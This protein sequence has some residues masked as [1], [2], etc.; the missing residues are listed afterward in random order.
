[1]FPL[2]DPK[3]AGH[4]QI[5]KQ[6]CQAQDFQP[7]P[8]DGRSS[9]SSG[10][11]RK[12]APERGHLIANAPADLAA[13]GTNAAETLQKMRPLALWERKRPF[14]RLLEHEH[15]S[16]VIAFIVHAA[17]TEENDRFFAIED[18]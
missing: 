4:S 14:Q 7:L 12:S 10:I 15:E 6:Q 5:R 2:V 9:S 17:V 8:G 3:A 18:R 1:L 16:R 11:I 13:G